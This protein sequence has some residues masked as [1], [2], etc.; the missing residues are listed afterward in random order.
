MIEYKLKQDVAKKFSDIE[1]R[2]G[3]ES[4]L[5]Y[6]RCLL[7]CFKEEESKRSKKWLINI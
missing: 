3:V 1:L 6:S 2:N 7:K 5:V 4:F